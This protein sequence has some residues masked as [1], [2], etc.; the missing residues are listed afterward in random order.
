LE[1]TKH[2]LAK[3]KAA[4]LLLQK[5]KDRATIYSKPVDPTCDIQFKVFPKTPEQIAFLEKKLPTYFI[6]EDL[7]PR[8]MRTLI[9]AMEQH[10]VP[11]GSTVGKQDGDEECFYVVETGRID[12]YCER[13]HHSVGKVDE[14]ASFGEMALLYGSKRPKTQNAEEDCVLWRIDQTTFRSILARHAHV[15]DQDIRE[16]L[17]KIDLFQNLDEQTLHKFASAMTQVTFE[18]DDQ[19]VEK[20]LVGDIFYIIEEGSVKVHDIGIG[21]S[22]SVDL[23]LKEG[24]W[25]GERALLTGEPRAANVTALTEV[26]TLAM[27]RETFEKSMGQLTTLMEHKE[28]VQ[29]IHAIPIF[30]NS[31]ID[32]AELNQLASL[33]KQVCFRKGHKLVEIGKPYQLNIW[34]IRHGR[35]LV[36]GGKSGKIHNLKSGDYFGDKSILGDP[37]YLSHHEATCEE[38][39]TTWVVTKE[40]IENVVGNTDRLGE[41][42]GFQKKVQ[43]RSINRMKDL[44]KHHILGQGA[45]GRVWLV[46]SKKTS[47]P[48]AL[49]MINKRKLVDSKQEKGVVREKELLSLLEHPFILGLESSFQDDANIYLVLPLVQ[50]G[51]LFNVVQKAATVPGIGLANNSAAFYSCCIAEALGHFHH[52]RIAYACRVMTLVLHRRCISS[53]LYSM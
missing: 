37:T 10:K 8:E 7:E 25:F 11:K 42:A 15:Y 9:D 18:K 16:R 4:N 22:Q 1:E 14:G 29:S 45:F 34:I 50:G 24:D 52:R 12:L 40:D 39:L 46:E 43:N 49:K 32:E 6:F 23:V 19:I 44:K 38:N 48:Y 27:D 51:E 28:I 33:A 26:K 30:A 2:S 41:T 17:K 13:G 21:D 3:S 31:N 5:R 36:Y 20:G 35:L 47:T 53:I